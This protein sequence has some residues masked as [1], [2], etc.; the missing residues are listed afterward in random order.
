MFRVLL[1]SAMLAAAFLITGCAG[2]TLSDTEK[3]AA[4]AAATS[5]AKLQPGDKIRI[6]VFG[7]DNL[8]GEY[9]LDQSG[10]ISLPLAGTVK[11]RGLSQTELEQEL[12]KKFRS[13]YLKS[14][15]VTVTITTLRPYYI[16]GE[17]K[18]PGQFAYQSGLNVLTALAIAGGPTYRASRNTVE[19]QRLGETSMREYPISA[20]VPILPGDVI[21][22]PER[23]F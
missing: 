16:I 19:I 11:V 5:P 3:E 7:E 12:A 1:C 6:V 18:S 21:K 9:Q 23:Y 8:T 14:P 20:A 22:V 13:Q 17:V 15:K 10:Q 2:S 4:V